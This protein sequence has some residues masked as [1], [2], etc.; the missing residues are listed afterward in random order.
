MGHFQASGDT[1]GKGPEGK[2]VRT[3]LHKYGFASDNDSGTS[4]NEVSPPYKLQR[5]DALHCYSAATHIRSTRKEDNKGWRD[6]VSKDGSYEVYT[7]AVHHLN[8]ESARVHKNHYRI[9]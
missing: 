7:K 2:A 9:P 3:A 8:E 4:A 1:Y 6:W 5:V